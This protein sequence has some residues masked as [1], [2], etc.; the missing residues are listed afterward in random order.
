MPAE[1][2]FMK[3]LLLTILVTILL[4]PTLASADDFEGLSSLGSQT[5]TTTPSPISFY[6]GD[7]NPSTNI[8]FKTNCKK[9]PSVSIA[10]LPAG[11][12]T[13]SVSTNPRSLG[14]SVLFV[15]V[16]FGGALLEEG[17]FSIS[18]T[19]TDACNPNLTQTTLYN[20]KVSSTFDVTSNYVLPSGYTGLAYNA[21]INFQYKGI[22]T[23]SVS[24]TGLPAGMTLSKV[25]QN[26]PNT[27]GIIPVQS[28]S[29]I[30]SGT[31][32]QSGFFNPQL[33]ITDPTTDNTD[34]Y[35]D[36]LSL[37]IIQSS[38]AP[39]IQASTTPVTSS[40]PGNITDLAGTNISSNG[41]VY[42]ITASGQ[43]RPYT[44]AGA[45]L[46]YGFNSW[47]DVVTA[48]SA[49]LALPTGNFIPP[50][51][52]KIIC[53]NKGSDTGTC[54]LITNSEK[55]AFTSSAVF[56]GL[57]FSFSNS[58]S[59]DVSFLNSAPNINSVTQTHP[60]GVLLNKGGTIYL[61]GNNGLLGVPD[62]NTLTSWG[63]TSSDSVLANSAD[64]ALPQ[65][66]VM[67]AHTAGAL[68]PF[69]N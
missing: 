61:V 9:L 10:G 5:T 31:P 37:T 34:T 63:Y 26:S 50:R 58:L 19:L 42:M 20:V 49:D 25:V 8:T 15:T 39:T 7:N 62:V 44:S 13:P 46:S 53:S 55:A 57:G 14:S 60:E 6:Y 21:A 33:F 41:T 54:Y 36:N 59:G 3:K 27:S 40:Q 69:G 52:G 17:Q 38:N 32:T 66:G 35:S 67:P 11:A 30:L 22:Y 68:N 1:R 24:F 12:F 51:D 16:S 23:P 29:V 48:S 28:Y 18:I 56:T 64:N 43:K 65:I 4:A 45:F 2:L 47:A